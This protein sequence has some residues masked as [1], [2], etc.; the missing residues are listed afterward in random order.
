MNHVIFN[1]AA[2]GVQAAT[3]FRDAWNLRFGFPHGPYS[4]NFSDIR[5]NVIA[6]IDPL[7]SAARAAV[8]VSCGFVLAGGDYE[9]ESQQVYILDMLDTYPLPAA[10]V[11]EDIDPNAAEW[12]AFGGGP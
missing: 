5:L 10:A 9:D 12:N 6:Q 7:D 4:Q 8:D 1:Q 11:V 2:G 3:E